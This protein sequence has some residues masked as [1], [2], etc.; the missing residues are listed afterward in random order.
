VQGEVA[1]Q[2]HL[3]RQDVQYPSKDLFPDRCGKLKISRD[4]RQVADV[5]VIRHHHTAFN[6]DLTHVCELVGPGE[7][8]SWPARG[9]I[10][11]LSVWTWVTVIWDEL[12]T[13][14]AD[15][16]VNGQVVEV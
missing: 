10:R 8:G 14:G 13:D 9:T 16:F 3:R 7:L 4:R 15:G 12:G 11:W 6:R 5:L 1:V 2:L